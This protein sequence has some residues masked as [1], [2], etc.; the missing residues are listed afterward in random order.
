MDN[1][2]LMTR[3]REGDKEAFREIYDKTVGS[4]SEWVKKEINLSN[5]IERVDYEDLVADCFYKLYLNRE[6]FETREH[7]RQWIYI[8]AKNKLID[9]KKGQPCR[10]RHMRDF[11][12][13]E[14]E[15][16]PLDTPENMAIILSFINKLP[17][18]QKAVI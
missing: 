12:M 3:F 14:E 16:K 11:P 5:F 1:S 18:Q 8:V 17:S 6:I 7:I 9:I 10:R 4:F 2:P 15:S 13:P